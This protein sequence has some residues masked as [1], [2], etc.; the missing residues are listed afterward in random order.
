MEDEKPK[1]KKRKGLMIGLSIFLFLLIG[2]GTTFALAFMGIINIPGITKKK[3]KTVV[4]G[5]AK[6]KPTSRR[7]PVISPT[8]KP[9][10]VNRPYVATEDPQQGA[11]KLAAVWNEMPTDKLSIILNNWNATQAARVLNEMEPE[12]AAAAL[13]ILEV[14]KSSAISQEMQVLGSKLKVAEN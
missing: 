11:I 2:G 6:P 5:K 13:A 10:S 3:S 14:K 4:A 1:K 9:P 7:S 12:R 8:V